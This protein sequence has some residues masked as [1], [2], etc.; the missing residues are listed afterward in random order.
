MPLV[1]SFVI[2]GD[3]LRWAYF[4]GLFTCLSAQHL[5]LQ[6]EYHLINGKILLSWIVGVCDDL[7]A[8]SIRKIISNAWKTYTPTRIH[9]ADSTSNSIQLIKRATLFHF[10]FRIRLTKIQTSIWLRHCVIWR[11]TRLRSCNE[12]GNRYSIK[13]SFFSYFSPVINI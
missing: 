3:H 12:H 1:L 13:S 2:S 9:A 6:R 11:L 10:C 7:I 8:Q 5:M 4:Q